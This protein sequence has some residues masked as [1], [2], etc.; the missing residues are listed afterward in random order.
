MTF[1]KKV[2]WWRQWKDPWLPGLDWRKDGQAEATGFL[3]QWKHSVPY[4][5]KGYFPQKPTGSTAARINPRVN[6]GFWTILMGPWRS[7]H[8]N[9]HPTPQRVLTWG[10]G[11]H[12]GEGG[13]LA[14]V[15]TFH[16]LLLEAQNCSKQK[17]YFSKKCLSTPRPL[18][19]NLTKVTK[20]KN[21]IS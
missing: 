14:E 20:T 19:N 9:K 18:Q 17:T 5:N 15:C 21:S 7:T 12:E 1:W 10:W 11:L 3:G 6:S 8:A 16:S 2:T 4:C 13:A